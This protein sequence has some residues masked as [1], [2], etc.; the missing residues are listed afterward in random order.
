M[1][2]PEQIFLSAHFLA[3]SSVVAFS[4]AGDKCSAKQRK[5][6]ENRDIPESQ[7]HSPERIRG[8][9]WPEAVT[10]SMSI[11]G[12]PII[13]STWIRLSFAPREASSSLVIFSP[14]MRQVE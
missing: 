14:W 6:Q 12:E 8:S 2:A 9:G 5:A 7:T 1:F 4:A 3:A 13:Q 11:S 10:P